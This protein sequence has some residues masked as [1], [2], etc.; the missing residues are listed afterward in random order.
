M[1]PSDLSTL[2]MISR[3]HTEQPMHLQLKPKKVRVMVKQQ[4]PSNL[5]F[6]D[7]YEDEDH[8]LTPVQIPKSTA[9]TPSLNPA[10]SGRLK[11]SKRSKKAEDPTMNTRD[12][13]ETRE[14]SVHSSTSKRVQ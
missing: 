1:N 2:M 5:G 8:V 10:P 14:L 4:Y 9:Q 11:P 7:E 6:V 3:L 12:A 13:V